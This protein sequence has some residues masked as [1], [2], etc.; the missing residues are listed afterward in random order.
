MF[1]DG[2][3]LES[4]LGYTE[5]DLQLPGKLD[6]AM[7][8]EYE[9]TGE[10]KESEGPWQYSGRYSQIYF[11]NVK[12]NKT[13]GPWEVTPLLYLNK[14][15][16]RHPVTGRIN[17]ADTYTYGADL[18]VNHNHHFDTATGVLTFGATGRWDDQK[19]DYYRYADLST[20]PSG[21]IIQVRSDRKGNWT[22]SQDRRVDL[23][24]VYAQE[25]FR[26]TD[27]WIV[28]AGLRYDEIK[29]K[30]SGTR[31]E[32]YSYSAG[33]YVPASDPEDVNKTFT[34]LSPRIGLTYKIT[35]GWNVYASYAKGLQAP[36]EGEISD[37]PDLD[38]VT[39]QNYEIGLKARAHSFMFDAAVYF[40]P[41]QDEVVQVIGPSGESDYV[42]S[43]ETKKRGFEFSG[44]WQVPWKSLKGLEI[45]ASYAYSDYTFK[46]FTEPV[47]SGPTVI[48]QDRSGNRL[49]FVPQHQYSF[50]GRYRHFSGVSLKLET[51]SWGSYYMDNANTEKYEGYGFATNAMLGYE[52]GPWRLSLN[53]EN[54]FDSRYAVEALK[55][56]QGDK[57]FTPA[58]PR[59]FMLQLVYN[60]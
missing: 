53:L 7:F 10:A 1:N 21:R 55:D 6:E 12:Y 43:G 4:Y 9:N 42:N 60:F 31:V 49:P 46:E 40:S 22:E 32:E 5:A 57:Q 23:Y 58:A 24:G 35:K 20:T 13:A 8:E 16:H 19:T 15:N 33:Q 41:V 50:Y 52:R 39:V 14:W 54:L 18:Q 47:R 2:A 59:T 45:G 30:I 25:S 48:N 37:N 34:G 3:T 28:D 26:P 29:M 56:T 27:R 44:A 51:F 38:P 17:E 11:A 36:T